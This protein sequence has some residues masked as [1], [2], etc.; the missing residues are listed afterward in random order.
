MIHDYTA[1]FNDLIEAAEANGAQLSEISRQIGSLTS[2]LRLGVI[3][4]G[5]VLLYMALK[6]VIHRD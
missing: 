4:V 6:G 3:L 1:Q 2:L 5:C